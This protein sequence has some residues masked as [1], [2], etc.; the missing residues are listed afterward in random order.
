MDTP[1]KVKS[2]AGAIV[3][4]TLAIAA[5][6]GPG[7]NAVEGMIREAAAQE[8]AANVEAKMAPVG[9]E[10]SSIKDLLRRK[11]D[12]ELMNECRIY[13]TAYPEGQLRENRCRRESEYR[14]RVWRWEDGG[15]EGPKPELE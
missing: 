7:K 11:E 14:W 2:W 5:V 13:R 12:R 10:L 3:A 4:V 9:R 8:A 15:R 6:I 1:T